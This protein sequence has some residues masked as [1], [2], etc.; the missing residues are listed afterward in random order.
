LREQHQ[1]ERATAYKLTQ[2]IA[3]PGAGAQCG[4]ITT[5]YLSEDEFHVFARLPAA[6]LAKTRHSI[7][8]FGVDVFEGELEGLILAEAE[9][10][11]AAESDGLVL[12]AF[13]GREVSADERFTGGRLAR[14]SREDLRTWLPGRAGGICIPCGQR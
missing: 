6:R 5:I 2:K 9:F 4:L 12:P 10:E 8:P 1:D 3:A 11:S 13:L 7:P 14:A